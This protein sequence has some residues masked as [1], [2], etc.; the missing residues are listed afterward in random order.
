MGVVKQAIKFLGDT[1]NTTA[2]I[3]TA[4]KKLGEPLLVSVDLVDRLGH[5]DEFAF[6]DIGLV[7]LRGKTEP[8]RLFRLNS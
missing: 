7:S 6:E 1:V 2:R 5:P 4:C 8:L 3:E